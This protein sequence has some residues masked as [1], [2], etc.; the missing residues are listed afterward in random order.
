MDAEA[1]IGPEQFAVCTMN[2]ENLFDAVDDG[3]GDLGDWTPADQAEFEAQLNKRAVTI[4][5][6]LL[7]CTIIGVQEVEGKDAVWEA[8]ARAVGPDFRY[9]YSRAPMCV[10][11][12]WGAV[13]ARRA[14]SAAA[15]RRRR[16]RKR[17]IWWTTWLP[18][19]RV[20]ALIP[21]ATALIRCSTGRPTWPT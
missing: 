4:R 12:P 19:A 16:A 15:S 21:A 6:D 14:H 8:L 7:G 2:L 20:P 11:S 10:T 13:R 1:A 9:D 17:T 18:T 5:E 3:D